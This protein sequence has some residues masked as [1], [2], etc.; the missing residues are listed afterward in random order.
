[1]AT[2]KD[3]IQLKFSVG[4]ISLDLGISLS[5]SLRSLSL[6]LWNAESGGSPLSVSLDSGV[7][8]LPGL[9]IPPWRMKCLLYVSLSSSSLL[10]CTRLQLFQING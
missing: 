9:S 7:F 8:P 3:L 6:S 1:M 5:L 2:T 10:T 4:V